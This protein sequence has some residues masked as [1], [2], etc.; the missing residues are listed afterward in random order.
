MAKNTSDELTTRQRQSLKI[1]REKAARKRRQFWQSRLLLV[2]LAVFSVT[3]VGGGL[4][5]SLSGAGARAWT[6]T[7]DSAYALTGKAGFSV[8]AIYLEGRN[9]TSM[10]VIHQ[11]LGIQRGDPIL[12]FSLDEARQRLEKIESVHFAAIERALPDAVYVRIIEREPVALWQHQGRLSLV[13]NNGKV[14]SGL[15]IAPYKQLPLI[16][17][18]NAPAHIGELIE[19]LS[20]DAELA[21][22]FIAAVRVGDRRWD[23]RLTNGI[24]VKLPETD[25]AVAWKALADMESRDKLLER[26]VKTIDLRLGGRLFITVNPQ[27]VPRGKGNAKET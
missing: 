2:G 22:Q 7:V 20:A 24:E 11:A 23:I 6:Q 5:L 26:S 19:I 15:D 18:D 8:Q 25:A 27:D 17:G 10:A 9:R 21:K 4:W 12:Q 14:M 16:V 1:M 3:V 13:D